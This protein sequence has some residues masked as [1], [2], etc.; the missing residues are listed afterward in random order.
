MAPK[1]N[2]IADRTTL[3]SAMEQVYFKLYDENTAKYGA[4]TAILLQVGKFFEVYD[5]VN[6]TTSLSRTN[7]E[8]LAEICG[9]V[10]EHKP[11]ADPNHSRLFWGFPEISLPKFERLLVAAGYTTVVHVQQKDASGDVVARPLDHIASPGTFYDVEGGL[12]IRPNEQCMLA[13]YVEPYEDKKKGHTHWHVGSTAFDVMTG[14]SVST[15]TDVVLIDGKPVFDVIT[16]FWAMYPPAEL[17]FYWCSATAPPSA[18]T[19]AMFFAATGGYKVPPV[20]SIQLDI[21]TENAAAT[22]RIRY[23]FLERV[24]KH[25]SAL[26]IGEYL[27]VSMYSF[28]RR[29]LTALL[30]FVEDHNPSYMKN[31]HQHTMWTPEENVLLGNAALTQLAMLPLSTDKQ[32]ESLLHWLQKAV[33]PM[34]KRTVRE[35]CLKPIA[36]IDELNERQERIHSLRTGSTAELQNALRGMYDLPRIY[37]RFQLGN[38]TVEDLLQLLTT[39]T[40]ANILLSLTKGTSSE[41]TDAIQPHIDSL[42]HRFDIER[43]RKN[44]TSLGSTHWWRRGIHAELD[45]MEDEWALLEANMLAVKETWN[46]LLKESDAIAWTLKEEEPFLFTTTQRRA[47][48]IVNAMKQKQKS[49]AVTA[50]KRTT[51]ASS[52]V[53]Q[54]EEIV[55]ANAAAV[56]IRTRWRAAIEE[57]WFAEWA[58]FT[59][60]GIR[61]NIFEDLANYIGQLDAELT[62]ANLAT[63]YGYVRPTYIES[64]VEAPAGLHVVGLRHPIIERVHE[65]SVYIPQSLS[66]GSLSTHEPESVDAST[67]AGMLLYGVNAAGKSS[68]GKAVGLSVLLAQCGIPVP[69]TKMTLIPYTG[70]FTRILGNDN[71]WAGMSSFVV[72]MTEFRSI[73]RAANGRTLVI[74]DELCSGTET[75]SAAAIVAAGIQS[76]ARRGANFIFATHLH[77]LADL[78]EITKDPSIAMYHLTV[79][80]GEK[81]ALVYDRRLYPGCGSPMYGLEVCRGLDMDT[82]FLEAAVSFRKRYFSDHVAPHASRYNAAVV[83]DRCTVCASTE[84]LE[85]HHIVPQA[86]AIDSKI[87]TAIHKNHAGNLV[88]L[89]TTC[90]DKHHAGLL[91]IKGW[92]NTSLG[93]KLNYS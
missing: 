60:E 44:V 62:F 10:V 9:C 18:D 82:E 43:V 17:V 72:E 3:G 35:R 25:D 14:S 88:V 5:Y 20:H 6:K 22:D 66:I 28:A 83:M 93:R 54:T 86:A 90:H 52:Y 78:P 11:S 15:E 30:Q 67:S 48:S 56:T 49:V 76:L 24:Y 34:G 41:G 29:S 63:N 55:K 81:N 75:A 61:S 26:T 13:I 57:R 36:D 65:T 77:E 40:K 79:H 2:K 46:A 92:M 58:I 39:Y 27:D 4:K 42:L 53:L 21:K 85:T 74:G 32:N 12:A 89:C 68:L 31:L 8:T 64:T 47:T 19:I 37:R 59:E 7:V 1:R 73:L 33:T 80:V 91:E 23:A 69:A 38:G 51:N 45:A 70:I 50:E 84:G 87:T 16:P 71:L